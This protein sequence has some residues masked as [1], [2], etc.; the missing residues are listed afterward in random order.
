VIDGDR[1]DD[2]QQAAARAARRARRIGGHAHARSGE[3]GPPAVPAS[4]GEAAGSAAEQSAATVSVATADAVEGTGQ[5]EGTEGTE[6]TERTERTERTEPMPAADPA[7]PD[8]RPSWLRRWL[9]ALVLAAVCLG[10]FGYGLADSRGIWWDKGSSSVAGERGAVLAAAKTCMARMNSYDYR[11][12]DADEKKGLACTT[13]TFTG[14]YKRAFEKLIKPDAGTA[15]FTQT[16]QI[17]NAGVESVSGDGKQ[18][19][20][21]IYG[22]LS[23]TNKQTGTKTPTLTAFGARVTMQHVGAKWLVANYQY[24]PNS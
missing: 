21:L 10:L 5:T 1:R 18:W 7:A 20:I 19:V 22:Q 17:N 6:G 4:P 8:G 3:S 16:A 9:P 14:Q 24:A 11:T 2:E 13:G 12:L 15:R 23:T